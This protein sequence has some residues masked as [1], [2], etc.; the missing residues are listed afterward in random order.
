MTSYA[1]GQQTFITKQLARQEIRRILH[2]NLGPIHG[3][4]DRQLVDD[5]LSAHP[6]VQ[7]KRRPGWQGVEVRQ[8]ASYT[9][10]FAVVYADAIATPFSYETCLGRKRSRRFL[11]KQAARA[12][13]LSQIH[14][15]KS[16]SLDGLEAW[17]DRQ[18][19]QV[20]HVAPNSL[21]F[22]LDKWLKQE[23]YQIGDILVHEVVINEKGK[24]SQLMADAEQAMS[25]Q[26]FHQ[27]HAKLELIGV[28]EHKART[29]EQNR[30]I[31][32]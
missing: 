10:H 22:L 21:S 15:F 20:D 29:I 30:H 31:S 12:A 27:Q 9:K 17:Q 14:L 8:D 11:V 23:G 18:D 25:W 3:K 5:L 26:A 2:T 13:V 16:E 28:D 1:I 7:H 24:P 32:Q 4:A 19:Y 6:G